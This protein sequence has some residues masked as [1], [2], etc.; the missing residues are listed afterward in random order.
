MVLLYLCM[1]IL[2]DADVEFE[3][4]VMCVQIGVHIEVRK[5]LRTWKVAFQGK[6]DR[7]E[8]GKNGSGGLSGV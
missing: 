2:S 3:F 4:L 5:L 1:H 6:E 8:A 7:P